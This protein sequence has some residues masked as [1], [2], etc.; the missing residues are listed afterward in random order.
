MYISVDPK[1]S[2]PVYVQLKQQL[3]LAVATGALQPGDQLPTLREL[4]N[5]VLVNPNTI[6]RVYRELQA[7]G[8]F[9][10]RQGS[11]TF[12]SEDAPAAGAAEARAAVRDRLEEA[13]RLGLSLRLDP[14]EIS[15]LFDEALRRANSHNTTSKGGEYA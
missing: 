7:E 1:S 15:R 3:R 6:G 10:A 13:A 2:V 4:A 9:N 12:V 8:L 14:S 5:Q 11:G